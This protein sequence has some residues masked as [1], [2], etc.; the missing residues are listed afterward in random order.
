[1]LNPPRALLQPPHVQDVNLWLVFILWYR[2]DQKH[3]L[4]VQIL[5]LRRFKLVH[6]HKV[7]PDGANLRILL[8]ILSASVIT[9]YKKMIDR[10]FFSCTRARII[11]TMTKSSHPNDYVD[12]YLNSNRLPS[13]PRMSPISVEWLQEVLVNLCQDKAEIHIQYFGGWYLARG[14]KQ[15]GGIFQ[16]TAIFRFRCVV[17]TQK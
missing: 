9:F 3:C 13:P 15:R 8:F 7:R 6:P 5:R 16:P 14:C 10:R 11:H 17:Y 2:S 4:L 12:S 1:M